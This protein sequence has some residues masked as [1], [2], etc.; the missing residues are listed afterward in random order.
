MRIIRWSVL[1]FDVI[2]LVYLI[3]QSEG[4]GKN[5]TIVLD[6]GH[7]GEDPG[8]IGL[9]GTYEKNVALKVVL[10][11]GKFLSD[12]LPVKVLYTRDKDTFITLYSRAEY[13][14]KNKANLF[15]SIHCNSA[16]YNKNGI[17][18]CN[19]EAD[20]MEIYVLG[21]HKTKANL[22]VAMREN[23]VI[24]MEKN[25]QQVYDNFDPT[26]EEHYIIISLKQNI[27]LHQSISL[28]EHI[29][30][31][32]E[33]NK[34]RGVKQAGFWVL[35]KVA[36]PSILIEL[37]FLTNPT[38]EEKFNDSSYLQMLSYQI[39]KGIKSYLDVI[40]KR[41]QVIAVNNPVNETNGDNLFKKFPDSGL[42][43]SVQVLATLNKAHS[44]LN[45]AITQLPIFEMYNNGIYKY[46]L[47]LAYSYKDA[48]ALR[49]SLK[50]V[51]F[52]DL[53]IISVYNSSIIPVSQAM[54]I[55][56]KSKKKKGFK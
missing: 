50:N 2:G 26:R 24:L 36:M 27:N 19:T 56:K 37:D 25:Y 16:C 20:G 41:Q 38:V 45:I 13:A 5:F 53:F 44:P 46:S 32:I 30:K 10:Y 48:V 29:V 11:L 47:G 14:N 28:A 49:D 51:G 4:N 40:S 54:E 22:E 35:Y 7:G 34:I 12:S 15:I 18:T 3:G 52:S 55:E 39:F 43:Y 17:K 31:S 6:A 8:C 1:L 33:K 21:L 23:S 9:K 42:Y